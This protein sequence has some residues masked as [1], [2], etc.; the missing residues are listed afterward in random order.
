MVATLASPGAVASHQSAAI[1]HEIGPLPPTALEELH[2]TR[3]GTGAGHGARWRTHR[4]KQLDPD[5]VVSIEG[6]DC[7]SRAR[8]VIDLAG[9]LRRSRFEEVF[10]RSMSVPGFDRE[11][12]ESLDRLPTRGKSGTSRIRQMFTVLNEPGR[13]IATSELEHRFLR[14]VV[15]FDLPAPE[16]QFLPPWRAGDG[17][18]RADF[19]YPSYRLLVEA[20]GRTWHTRDRAF[21]ADRRR[22]QAATVAGWSTLRF[23]WSQIV[24]EA[25]DV[26]ETVRAALAISRAA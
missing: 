17:I 12:A 21:E 8:T 15:D 16:S 10:H 25:S 26:A 1:L 5:D 13:P 19:A 11:L 7:T 4:V 18:G 24:D 6:I 2:L 3:L 22:D 23:T 9:A 20:D 14:L